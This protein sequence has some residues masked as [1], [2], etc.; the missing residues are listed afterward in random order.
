MAGS[1][2][3]GRSLLAWTYYCGRANRRHGTMHNGTGGL[4]A[5]KTAVAEFEKACDPGNVIG[6]LVDVDK[7]VVAFDLDGRVQGACEI[8][9]EKPLYV[10]TQMDTPWDHVELRKPSLEEAPPANLEALTGA[11]L[12]ASKGEALHW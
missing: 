10:I 8:P 5:C 7:R 6:M 9:G 2:V 3:N 12:D 4:H 1:R 11:L